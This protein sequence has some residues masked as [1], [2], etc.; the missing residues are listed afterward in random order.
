[1]AATESS[2]GSALCSICCNNAVNKRVQC[3]KCDKFYH[4]SCV[5][6][7]KTKVVCLE[8]TKI[9]CCDASVKVSD[10]DSNVLC[11]N[12]N[13]NVSYLK[14]LLETKDEL[15][16]QLYDKNALLQDKIEYLEEKILSVTSERSAPAKPVYAGTNE[17]LP[18]TKAK[19]SL[20][21]GSVPSNV[22]SKS[23]NSALKSTKSLKS[24]EINIDQ[25]KAAV[26]EAQ[27]ATKLNHII[28]LGGYE[29]YE[30]NETPAKKSV[31]KW[32]NKNAPIFGKNENADIV[33]IDKC[34]H[35]FLSRVDPKFG[36]DDIKTFLNK[37]SVLIRGCEQL[38]TRYDTYK[39]FKLS[40]NNQ[41]VSK[42]MNRDLW[43]VNILIKFFR[44][45]KGES[46]DFIKQRRNQT[47]T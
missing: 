24:D 23:Y 37:N 33:G 19:D 43:G 45:K 9:I 44:F 21:I 29:N 1:M 6:K 20:S 47:E 15:I 14:L 5:N 22:K 36:C 40:V 18:K 39:S 25:V 42:V 10:D 17:G 8:K 13:D 41:D 28:N 7:I 4:N 30:N 38:N 26:A 31:H 2:S 27:T 11:D 46:Q 12:G 35:L 16:K 3:I 34:R 32:T